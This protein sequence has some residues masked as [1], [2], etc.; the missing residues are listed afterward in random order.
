VLHAFVAVL[1][2]LIRLAEELHAARRAHV[3]VVLLAVAWLLAHVRSGLGRRVGGLP[4]YGYCVGRPVYVCD[5]V[6]DVQP[7]QRFLELVVQTVH[8]ARNRVCYAL[9]EFGR[10]REGRH[11]FRRRFCVVID[12]RVGIA[13]RLLLMLVVV[14]VVVVVLA[15]AL[16][17]ALALPMGL[18]LTVVTGLVSRLVFANRLVSIQPIVVDAL[19]LVLVLVLVVLVIVL[20]VVSLL[21]RTVWRTA[22]GNVDELLL[23]RRHA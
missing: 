1:V 23:R 9:P 3:A 12:W 5:V 17:L 19:V 18:V 4:G 15:L 22:V 6:L 8:L 7:T 21:W 2:S 11:N 13:F 14:L 10:S 20:V 16:M